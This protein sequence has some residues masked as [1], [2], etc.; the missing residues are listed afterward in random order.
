[1]S[2]LSFN[3]TASTAYTS[4]IVT[5]LGR[6]QRG[7]EQIDTYAIPERSGALHVLSGVYNS[8]TREMT[9]SIKNKTERAAIASWLKGSGKLITSDDAN[10]YF[11]AVV[12]G[13]D[14]SRVS[15]K[16]DEYRVAFEVEPY[17]YLDSGVAVVTYT[18]KPQTLVNPGTA[19]A[20]PYI[21]ITGSG[22]VTLT[23][24]S[25]VINLTIDTYIEIDTELLLCYKGTENAGASMVGE[26]PKLA[27][28]ANSITWT[29]TVTKVEI[30]PR[31]REL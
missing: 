14:V 9:L 17:F 3:G 8:Y 19:S 16:F 27:V 2:T 13:F 10:G 5:D 20:N 25:T 23:V 4:L 31:W 11:N 6:R 24:N 30:T 21:K 26:F 7:Q 1:M 12:T 18:T 15:R 29:G 22:A 28:G